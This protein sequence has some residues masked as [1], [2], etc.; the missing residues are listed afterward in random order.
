MKNSTLG[1]LIT[2]VAFSAAAGFSIQAGAATPPAAS[3]QDRAIDTRSISV[4]YAARDLVSDEGRAALYSKIRHAARSVCGP[5]NLRE[6]GSLR[7]M[8]RNQQCYNSAVE[9]AVS[10]VEA[11]QVAILSN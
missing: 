8:S 9:A 2:A 1:S 4:A 10:Q 11:R 3:F 6:A 5:T 7:I